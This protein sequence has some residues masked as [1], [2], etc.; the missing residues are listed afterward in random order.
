MEEGE[1]KDGD[2]A[3]ARSGGGDMVRVMLVPKRRPSLFAD[4]FDGNLALL[5]SVEERSPI[6]ISW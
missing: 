2:G 1:E 4:R 6:S 5:S 3:D